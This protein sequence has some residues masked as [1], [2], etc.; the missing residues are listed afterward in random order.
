MI[1]GGKLHRDVNLE[2]QMIFDWFDAKGAK[3]F[4]ATLANS[5][6]TGVPDPQRYGDK[7]FE[8][9]AEKVLK[10]MAQQ[11][12][13]FKRQGKLNTFKKAQLGNAFRWGLIDAG[14]DK[15]YADKL[16]QWLMLQVG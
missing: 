16:T 14:F 10:Q 9:K 2:K 5:F 1:D 15:S 11:V 3:A 4:G 13:V 6:V 7:A 8:K 12:A